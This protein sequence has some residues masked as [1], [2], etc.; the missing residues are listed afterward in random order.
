MKKILAVS[1]SNSKNSINRTLLELASSKVEG[2][3]VTMLDIRD[4]PMPFFS[5]DREE[6]EG[7][8]ETAKQVRA[9]FAEYDAF[10]ISSPEHNGSMP[11]EFKNLI[12]WVSRLGDLQNP[13]FATNKPVFL[14]S[15][16]PGPRGG[17]T[18]LQALTQ[19]MPFWGAD[20]RGSYSLGSFYDYFINGKLNAEKEQELTHSVTSFIN[21]L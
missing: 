18:N 4:Y 16:S 5:L 13:M 11:A 2:Y 19:L 8:P 21:G 9:L 6:N 15:T 10:I 3:G 12:D 7:H 17:T 1:A 20:V 14:L